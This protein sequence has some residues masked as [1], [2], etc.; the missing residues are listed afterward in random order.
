MPTIVKSNL[1]ELVQK[2]ERRNSKRYTYTYIA[3]KLGR[4]RQAVERLI[5]EGQTNDS[6]I[7]YGLLAK[8][9]DFFHEEGLEDV[10]LADLFTVID[11]VTPGEPKN[12]L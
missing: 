8:L 10:T 9:L 5:M 1:L 3:E 11:A 7:K 4:T 2:L 6:Y 12:S